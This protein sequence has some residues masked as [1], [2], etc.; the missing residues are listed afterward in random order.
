MAASHSGN[1]ILELLSNSNLTGVAMYVLGCAHQSVCQSLPH[2][3][4]EAPALSQSLWSNHATG[5]KIIKTLAMLH[6]RITDLLPYWCY[7]LSCT[8]A[9]RMSS[10]LHHSHNGSVDMP[11]QAS[12]GVGGVA[13][14]V[15]TAGRTK[16]RQ[17][18]LALI[19][20]G[21]LR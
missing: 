9:T 21:Y 7:H 20:T 2:T 14:V 13:I 12:G 16:E 8:G 19:H 11:H 10:I 15:S 4:S 18:H 17:F 5:M 1:N 6:E 3:H